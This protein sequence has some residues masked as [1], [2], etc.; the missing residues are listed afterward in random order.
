[1]ALL[2]ENARL[3]IIAWDISRKK[4][5][6]AF[7]KATAD[8]EVSILS[9]CFSDAHTEDPGSFENSI[10]IVTIDVKDKGE[11]FKVESELTSRTEERSRVKD[12]KRESD[13]VSHNIQNLERALEGLEPHYKNK[14]SAAETEKMT[15]QLEFTSR[16][17]ELVVKTFV[18]VMK[19]LLAIPNLIVFHLLLSPMTFLYS[20]RAWMPAGLYTDVDKKIIFYMLFILY[21]AYPLGYMIY[22]SVAYEVDHFR[23]QHEQ[24]FQS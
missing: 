10:K 9:L 2:E 23:P 15:K 13:I 19:A 1:M 17:K 20:Q 11:V 16:Y 8:D 6:L 21:F 24:R 3:D 22:M 4:Q 5:E 14:V 7:M 18:F 12:P